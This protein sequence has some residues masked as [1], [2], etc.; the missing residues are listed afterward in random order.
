MI[1]TQRVVV[2]V[3]ITVM[4][5]VSWVA[6]TAVICQN[7]KMTAINTCIE[8]DLTGQVCADSKGTLM[9]SGIQEKRFLT[10]WK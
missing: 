7:P 4:G 8:A 10:F 2:F 9:Y 5:D 6:Q 1:Y 3:M